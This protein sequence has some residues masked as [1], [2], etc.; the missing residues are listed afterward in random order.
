MIHQEF[1]VLILVVRELLCYYGLI[2]V[3]SLITEGTVIMGVYRCCVC[4]KELDCFIRPREL[5][6]PVVGPAVRTVVLC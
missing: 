1:S 4:V 5:C 2:K 6:E 3:L